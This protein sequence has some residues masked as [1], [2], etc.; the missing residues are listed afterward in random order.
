MQVGRGEG[1]VWVEQWINCA[2]QL[3]QWDVLL[4]FAR[5][6]DNA[7]LSMECM[8]RLADWTGLRE[9][10]LTKAQVRVCHRAKCFNVFLG[11]K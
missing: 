4:D 6:T 7:L 10:M 3:T 5:S 9:H 8:W 11:W 2:K 1:A